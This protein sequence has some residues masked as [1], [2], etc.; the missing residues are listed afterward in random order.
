[1]WVWCWY[2]I[3]AQHVST[4]TSFA[5]SSVTSDG[6]AI[7]DPVSDHALIQ[8]RGCVGLPHVEIERAIRAWLGEYVMSNH[9]WSRLVRLGFLT[10][11]LG[12]ITGPVCPIRPAR[13]QSLQTNPTSSESLSYALWFTTPGSEGSPV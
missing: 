7:C 3:F 10:L 12:L 8:P 6:T 5:S 11:F 1:M 9:R 13:A 4:L 2:L